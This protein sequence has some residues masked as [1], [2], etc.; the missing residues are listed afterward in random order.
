MFLRYRKLFISSFSSIEGC[1]SNS[2]EL[3]RN[4]AK[5]AHTVT[6]TPHVLPQL[7]KGLV[8]CRIG[9]NTRVSLEMNFLCV[10]VK[11]MVSKTFQLLQTTNL[12]MDE[13]VD[14]VYSNLLNHNNMLDWIKNCIQIR[15]SD[16]H[17]IVF[18]FYH[19]T[20]Q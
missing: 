1:K 7:C 3:N 6:H 19:K 8:H 14:V 2:N 17:Y 10:P 16:M 13:L 11:R 18:Y 15:N 12:Q 9:I 20:L 5:A 4:A